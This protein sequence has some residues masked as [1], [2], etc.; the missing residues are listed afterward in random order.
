MKI[1]GKLRNYW[2][3]LQACISTSCS[4]KTKINCKHIHIWKLFI[5]IKFRGKCF[6]ILMLYSLKSTQWV[7][8]TFPGGK[9]GRCVR[10]TTLPPSCAVVMKSVNVTSW[11][12]LGHSRP[13]TGLFTFYSLRN[14]T[15]AFYSV[16]NFR[17]CTFL[18]V[19]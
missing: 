16:V 2:L 12:P 18:L 8:G 13:V 9:G 11:N 15:L 5:T 1:V 17:N 14:V 3:F 7:P 19:G 6:I 4:Q 10:L